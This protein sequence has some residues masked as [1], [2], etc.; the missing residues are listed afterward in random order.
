MP[1]WKLRP[2]GRRRRCCRRSSRKVSVRAER[3]RPS[4]RR[5]RGSVGD[6]VE[7]LAGGGAG[8]HRPSPGAKLGRCSPSPPAARRARRRSSS[9]ASSGVGSRVALEHGLPPRLACLR[10]HARPRGGSGS[11]RSSRHRKVGSSG[12]PR[13]RP[14]WPHLLGAERRAVGV[15]A[16]PACAGCRSRCGCARRSAKGGRSRPRQSSIARVD[17]VE[18]VAVGDLLHVPAVRLVAPGRRPR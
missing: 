1:K 10:P 16:C 3:G 5:A 12:Q 9:A 11:R 4:R 7:H 17:G 6:R 15:V 13:L 18:V 8:R 2:P 14:W